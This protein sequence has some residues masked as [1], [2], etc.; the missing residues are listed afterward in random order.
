[1]AKFERVLYLLKLSLKDNNR[2]NYYSSQRHQKN[3][4]S[5]SSSREGVLGMWNFKSTMD[6]TNSTC[7]TSPKS[8]MRAIMYLLRVQ[9]TIVNPFPFSTTYSS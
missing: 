4:T 3:Q 2:S 9:F 7:Q 5:K 8:V 1:M 6:I